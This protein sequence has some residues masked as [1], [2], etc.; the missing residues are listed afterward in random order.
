[1]APS[2]KKLEAALIDGTCEVFKVEP[3]AT[4]VNKVR[5][6][7]EEKLGLEDGFFQ[8]EEWKS[9]SKSLIKHYVVGIARTR[10]T[11]RPAN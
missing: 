3:D 6:Q 9:R 1:M 7:V 4:S 10:V 8:S 2:A 11:T 5:K